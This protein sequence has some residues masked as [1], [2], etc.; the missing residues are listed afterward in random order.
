MAG[1]TLDTGALI[2]FERL[3]RRVLTHLKNAQL[4]GLELTVPT[5]VIAE[6]WRGGARSARI[7]KL[8][9]AC[10]VEP[11]FDDLARV[12]GESIAATTGATVV[13]AIVMASAASRGDR[14]LTSDFDDLDGL[15]AYFPAVRL[16]AV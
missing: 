12:A 9:Q 7:A 11:L 8:L 3:D 13:D 14:V 16:L 1:L 15:R 4:L 5:A 2:G 10:S 6:A